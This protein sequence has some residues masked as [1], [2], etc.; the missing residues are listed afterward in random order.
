MTTGG[1][2]IKLCVILLLTT[3]YNDVH[4]ESTELLFKTIQ[5]NAKRKKPTHQPTHPEYPF[6]LQQRCQKLRKMYIV[7]KDTQKAP[8]SAT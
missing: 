7:Q 4:Y 6:F 8:D 3:C 1:R 2:I 5:N